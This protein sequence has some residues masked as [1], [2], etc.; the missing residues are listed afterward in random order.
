ML[1]LFSAGTVLQ[2]KMPERIMAK[3]SSSV[4]YQYISTWKYRTSSQSIAW[5]MEVSIE[6][7][8]FCS[9]IYTWCSCRL[10][11]TACYL[12][13]SEGD[14][15]LGIFMTKF[16]NVVLG[17][18]CSCENLMSPV[19]LVQW[20]CFDHFSLI[21]FIGLTNFRVA[22]NVVIVCHI[23]DVSAWCRLWDILCRLF[24]NSWL[25]MA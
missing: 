2:W 19:V 16:L 25:A 12:F 11:V 3:L 4:M 13:V 17:P 9:E 1:L 15:V 22:F 6:W 18:L 10:F 5:S 24:Q 20:S 14:T 7:K 23:N 8:S 21:D